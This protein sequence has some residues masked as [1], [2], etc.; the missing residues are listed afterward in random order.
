MSLNNN[1]NLSV[2]NIIKKLL[3]VRQTL[4]IISKLHR[5]LLWPPVNHVR[6][7]NF[8]RLAPISNTFGLDR[9]LPIDRY[10]IEKFLTEN[11]NDIY[12]NV[13]EIGND[14]YTRKYG[15][16]KVTKS[17]ILHVI[18]GNEKASIVADLTKADSIPSNTFNCIILTQTLQFIFDISAAV[19]TLHRILIPGGVLLVTVPGISRISR[20]DMDR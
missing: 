18:E 13:L 2:K 15:H 5:L 16:E 8:R 7:G 1:T 3:P 6:F 10:Y 17:D 12:G 4:H 11:K 14:T 20:Y 9:G 19:R